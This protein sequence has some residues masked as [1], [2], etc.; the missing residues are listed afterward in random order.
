MLQMRILVSC[1]VVYS[2][3]WKGVRVVDKFK[4]GWGVWGREAV[5]ITVTVHVSSIFCLDDAV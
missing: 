4:V 3:K 1:L 2:V 5:S